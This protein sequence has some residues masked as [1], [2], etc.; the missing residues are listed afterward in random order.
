MQIKKLKLE[1][2]RKFSSFELDINQD[3]LLL[4][5][6]NA[7]GKTNLLEAIHVLS[8]GKSF[9]LNKLDKAIKWGEE[10][11]RIQ[12]VLD[13]QSKLEV[14]YSV[15]P[16]RQKVSKIN[17]VKK[18]LNDFVGNFLTV[19]FTP[20]DID[21]V[22][23]APGNRRRFLDILLSQI[24]HQYLI[25]LLN[26]QKVLKHRNKLLKAIL[27]NKSKED[28]L[29]FWDS[30]LAEH[31][32]N[33]VRER[34]A[35]FEQTKNFLTHQYQKISGTQENLFLK[36]HAR[37]DEADEKKYIQQLI[38]RHNRDIQLCETSSGP[39]RDDF[40]FMLNNKPLISFGSRGEYRSVILALKLTEVKFIEDKKEDK[41]VLLLDDVFSELD[42]NRKKF[43]LNTI[44]KQ[45]TIITTTDDS[46]LGIN[47]NSI[48]VETL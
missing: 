34:K 27:E 15:V 12:G 1:N 42:T 5:G 14:F 38:K 4:I 21:L 28:E 9:R 8:I 24:S 16:R 46:V 25:D 18:K 48:Q 3:I 39:H 45:Q 35:F 44:K 32:I 2:F 22:S 6:K 33:I 19:L 41:P 31:G 30:R 17:G 36:Y 7:Q 29:E 37:I 43:L 23:A 40:E 47:K 20:E 11:L 26:Y 10:Y 13:N